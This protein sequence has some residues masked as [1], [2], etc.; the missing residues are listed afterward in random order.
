MDLLTVE[1]LERPADDAALRARAAAMP[2]ASPTDALL[3]GGTW[4]FSVPQPHLR[5]LVDLTTL[6]WPAVSTTPAGVTVAATATI[7]QLVEQLPH[8]LVQGCAEALVGSHKVWNV[9]TVGGNI[10]LALPAGPMTT[11]AVTLDAT[12]VVWP[13]TGGETR[14]PVAD[15]VVGDRRTLLAAGDVLRA[16]ELPSSAL[17]S[18]T[19]LRKASLAP[20]GRSAALLGG[21]IDGDGAVTLAVTAARA[22]PAVL[23]FPAAPDTAELDAAVLGLEADGPW[24][25]D[26]HGTPAWRRAMTRRLAREIVEELT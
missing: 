19:A 1:A 9:A 25:D 20:L 26:P 18:R 13:A 11:L 14:L 4:L 2:A 21:R 24:F 10:A 6:P 17:R 16:V 5:T 3:A 15:L 23:R 22:R 12:A 8:P 7:A